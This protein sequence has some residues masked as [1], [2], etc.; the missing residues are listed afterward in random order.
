[1]QNQEQ[2]A[3]DL[4]L[5][6]LK[7]L[8]NLLLAALN[9]EAL[10]RQRVPAQQNPLEVKAQ[11]QITVVEAV[12]KEAFYQYLSLSPGDRTDTMVQVSAA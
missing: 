5:E 11:L 6:A 12:Q 9:Q 4:S 8:L 10:V 3:V 1:M 2:A 7:V